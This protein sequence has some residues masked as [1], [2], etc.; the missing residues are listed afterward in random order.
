MQTL[1]GHR[2]SSA[3]SRRFVYSTAAEKKQEAGKERSRPGEI[4]IKNADGGV[5]S[6]AYIEREKRRE[7]VS[8]G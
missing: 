6:E 7:R 4:R 8:A 3:C 5:A 1:A 2:L